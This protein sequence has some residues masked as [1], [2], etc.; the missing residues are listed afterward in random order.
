MCKSRSEANKNMKNRTKQVVANAMEES[1]E[2]ELREVSE[3]PNMVFK[4]EV[5][6][7]GRERC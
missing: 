4:L 2:Q 5:D 7:N 1:A 3:H 6:E